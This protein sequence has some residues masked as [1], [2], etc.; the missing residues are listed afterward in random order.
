[1]CFFLSEKLDVEFI[2]VNLPSSDGISLADEP[3]QLSAG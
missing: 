2:E 1:V 3:K